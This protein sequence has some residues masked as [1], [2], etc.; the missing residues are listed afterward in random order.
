LKGKIPIVISQ[1]HVY[2]VK[3]LGGMSLQTAPVEPRGLRH[4]R[5][6]MLVDPN[7]RFLRE[8]ALPRMALISAHAN[9][10]ALVLQAPAQSPLR[11]ELMP[12]ATADLM[13]V[14]VWDSA[15]RAVVVSPAADRWLSDFLHV[16]CRLVQ[17]PDETQ[18]P[19]PAEDRQ[20]QGIVSFADAFPLLLLGEASLQDLN[21]RLAVPVPTD[22][23]R[24][25]IVVSG[26]A[27]YA[28]DDWR[29]ITL[30]ETVFQVVQP[31]ARCLLTTINQQ[32]GRSDGSEPLRTLALYRR[33]GEKV[34]FGQYLI[35]AASGSV[36]VGM[37]VHVRE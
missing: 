10:A 6:W 8:R 25:N 16:P 9:G 1:I 24:P 26:V 29:T 18:R 2:P 11:V 17:M 15:C 14:R 12:P 3:S 30:G 20:T 7:G 33:R 36:S 37:N 5:R 31:C 4:D 13:D 28:E 27:P 32:T 23:F 34:V 22:R 35:P 21:Q 19:V